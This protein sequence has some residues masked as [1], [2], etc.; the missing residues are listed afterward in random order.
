MGHPTK[1]SEEIKLRNDEICR[2]ATSDPGLKNTDI[3]REFGLNRETVRGVLFRHRKSMERNA[4]VAA[5]FKG[6]F[7]P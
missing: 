2:R 4:R 5:K 6:V 1:T 7:T 3:G